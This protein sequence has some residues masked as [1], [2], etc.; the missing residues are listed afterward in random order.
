MIDIPDNRGGKQDFACLHLDSMSMLL[1]T[2]E[3]SLVASAMRTK[4]G[5][6]QTECAQALRGHF[7]GRPQFLFATSVVWYG[8]R[9]HTSP[10]LCPERAF[11]TAL[12]SYAASWIGRRAHLLPAVCTVL[13]SDWPTATRAGSGRRA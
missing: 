5:R 2:V 12:A 13:A 7:F 8:D 3:P 1:A 10:I 4:L 6:F 11:P 9:H